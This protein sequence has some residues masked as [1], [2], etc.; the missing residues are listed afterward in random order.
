MSCRTLAHT[1]NC[2]VPQKNDEYG[3]ILDDWVTSQFIYCYLLLVELSDF[4]CERIEQ[5]WQ[6]KS[7]YLCA[8]NS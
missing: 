5:F 3:V 6:D 1:R 8:L 7:V 4:W 2:F